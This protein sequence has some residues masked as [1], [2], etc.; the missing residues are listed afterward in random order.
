M[1]YW[2]KTREY[3]VTARE[4]LAPPQQHRTRSTYQD[5]K[6][7]KQERQ[8]RHPGCRRAGTLLPLGAVQRPLCAARRAR[9]LD[10]RALF[11]ACHTGDARTHDKTCRVKRVFALFALRVV[12]SPN[13]HSRDSCGVRERDGILVRRADA[14]NGIV[15]AQAELALLLL[16][17]L[18]KRLPHRLRGRPFAALAAWRGRAVC[19]DVRVRVRVRVCM[20]GRGRWCTPLSYHEHGKGWM[21]RVCV[22]G[23]G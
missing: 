23:W 6:E 10:I 8:L 14:A 20:R 11:L 16:D 12:G 22:C 19:V 1:R 5:T 17:A 7:K 9:D 21:V 4:E 15:A 3:T 2:N 13:V 18:A